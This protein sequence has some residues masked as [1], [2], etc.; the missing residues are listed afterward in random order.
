MKTGGTGKTSR[1]KDKSDKFTVL[2]DRVK[3]LTPDEARA[4]LVRAGIIDES[5]QLTAG[6]KTSKFKKKGAK[7]RGKVGKV[8]PPA[9]TPARD[10]V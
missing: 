1:A 6:Y 9:T 5:G 10:A 3:E 7:R 8:K 2:V 4:Q